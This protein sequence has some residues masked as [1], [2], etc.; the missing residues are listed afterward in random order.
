MDEQTTK[1]LAAD[2]ANNVLKAT[3]STTARDLQINTLENN[4]KNMFDQNTKEHT[5]ITESLSTMASKLDQLIDK[6][7]SRYARSWTEKAWIWLL[8]IIG[9]VSIGLVIRWVITLEL[10]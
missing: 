6:M 8:S 10:K 1:Q 7:D 2:I 5:S 9:T 4:Y 3:A